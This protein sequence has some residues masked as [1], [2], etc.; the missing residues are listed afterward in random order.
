MPAHDLAVAVAIFQRLE[1][2]ADLHGKS[3]I[4]KWSGSERAG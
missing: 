1:A 3:L 2:V 4:Q